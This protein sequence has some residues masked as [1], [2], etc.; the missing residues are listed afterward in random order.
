MN[1]FRR[2]TFDL[3]AGFG[4]LTYSDRIIR[5]KYSGVVTVNVVGVLGVADALID[6]IPDDIIK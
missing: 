6:E 3:R 2:S 5:S 4:F 1:C